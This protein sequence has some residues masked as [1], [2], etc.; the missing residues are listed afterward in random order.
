MGSL[1]NSITVGSSISPF[2]A[3]ACVFQAQ[4]RFRDSFVSLEFESSS[5][6]QAVFI[7]KLIGEVR[8]CHL[9]NS[10]PRN[11]QF[12]F[13]KRI[14]ILDCFR[15]LVDP[16]INCMNSFFFAEKIEVSM[17]LTEEL[18]PI[19]LIERKKNCTKCVLSLYVHAHIRL[20]YLDTEIPVSNKPRC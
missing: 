19:D 4:R 9:E 17:F 7:A 2:R 3:V 12:L 20:N 14:A 11:L 10:S 1:L 8:F 6:I 13:L 18:Y 5:D 15:T 16:T